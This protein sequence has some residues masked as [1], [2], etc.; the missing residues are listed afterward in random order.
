VQITEQSAGLRC[1]V[2][3]ND[4]CAAIPALLDSQRRRLDCPPSSCFASC[5][6]AHASCTHS[7]IGSL[8]NCLCPRVLS[9]TGAQGSSTVV[10][11]CVH[12]VIL[13]FSIFSKQ[14]GAKSQSKSKMKLTSKFES[15]PC[16]GRSRIMD[17]VGVES[18]SKSK[19]H[20]ANISAVNRKVR[21]MDSSSSAKLHG[22]HQ[23]YRHDW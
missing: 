2:D 7:C 16:L 5:G 14:I 11:A 12:P 21:K 6:P 20:V 4:D 15:N 13:L 19:T 18:E 22:F 10:I 9:R 17:Q 23:L 1:D 8:Y 3:A